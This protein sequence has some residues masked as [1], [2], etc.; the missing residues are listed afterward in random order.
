MG[1][2]TIALSRSSKCRNGWAVAAV[3]KVERAGRR[4]DKTS[5]GLEVDIVRSIR[6]FLA[7][8]GPAHP[9]ADRPLATVVTYQA[10]E[11]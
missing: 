7:C 3:A 9:S 1:K 11:K 4:T 5:T 10:A 2:I 6:A 8:A